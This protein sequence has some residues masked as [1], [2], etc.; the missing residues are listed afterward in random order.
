MVITFVRSFLDHVGQLG[1]IAKR[2]SKKYIPKV[3]PESEYSPLGSYYIAS[4]M[5][6]T[7]GL[8]SSKKILDTTRNRRID[9]HNV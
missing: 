8:T 7:S 9:L 1:V 6:E 5:W 4:R 3:N 2:R